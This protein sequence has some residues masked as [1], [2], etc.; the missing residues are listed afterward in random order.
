MTVGTCKGLGRLAFRVVVR[1]NPL[2]PFYEVVRFM[3]Y[4]LTHVQSVR[5]LVFEY[6]VLVPGTSTDYSLYEYSYS[7]TRLKNFN[8]YE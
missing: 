5:V 4:R 1:V 7:N 6:L 2:G 3:K 8:N